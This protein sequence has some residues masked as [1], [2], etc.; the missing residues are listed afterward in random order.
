MDQ[1]IGG[2]TVQ[3]CAKLLIPLHQL[4]PAGAPGSPASS[5]ATQVTSIKARQGALAA[6]TDAADLEGSLVGPFLDAGER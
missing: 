2:F 3:H 5:I 4:Q 1:R 6:M